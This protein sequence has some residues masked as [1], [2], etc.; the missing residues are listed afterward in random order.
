MSN[1]QWPVWPSYSPAA[2]R[3]LVECGRVFDYAGSEP[4]TELEGEFAELDDGMHV[5][6]F[7][8]ETSALFAAFAG[9]GGGHRS[10]NRNALWRNL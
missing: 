4:V 10:Q 2:S 8:S 9:L 3:R 6:S 1:K 7:N 5:L